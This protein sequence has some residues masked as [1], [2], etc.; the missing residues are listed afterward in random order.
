MHVVCPHC[1]S[2]NRVP[3]DRAGDAPKC[4][5][6]DGPLLTGEPLTLDVRNFD[7]TIDRND[8]PVVVDS[9][10]SW[11]GPCRMMAPAFARSARSHAA[12][13]VFGELDTDAESAIAQRYGIRSI[14]TLILFKGG[15]EVARV[16]GAMD[17]GSLDRWVAQHA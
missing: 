6:C 1:L 14:P 5:K 8:L 13:A 3:E 11:C 10:A 15:R 16:S 7:K 2:V 12:R 9:W 4:A 17:A